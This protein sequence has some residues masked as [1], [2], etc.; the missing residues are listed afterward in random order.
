MAA[1]MALA[2]EAGRT[3]RLAGRIPVRF[4]AEP[5]SGWEG[6]ADL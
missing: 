5:S 4:H 2:V 6:M 1:A 3:A